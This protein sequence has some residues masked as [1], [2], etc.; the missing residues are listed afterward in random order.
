MA[1][2]SLCVIFLV[3]L[4]CDLAR[5]L[6]RKV[7]RPALRVGLMDALLSVETC[8]VGFEMGVVMELHGVGWWLGGIFAN[9]LYQSFRWHGLQPPIPYMLVTDYLDGK[10]TLAAVAWRSAVMVAAGLGT[11]RSADGVLLVYSF[12]TT[13]T[14][15][16]MPF[17]SLL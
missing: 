7:S 5:R 17:H 2:V 14:T 1:F 11:Y 9:C 8:A 6:V 15:I 12:L 13:R 3:L 4:A 10:Q 16:C